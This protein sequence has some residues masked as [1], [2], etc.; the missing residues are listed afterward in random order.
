MLKR[1]RE[2]ILKQWEEREARLKKIRAKEKLMEERG[3]KRR[4]LEDSN[5]RKHDKAVNDEDE[6]L[7]DQDDDTS[8]GDDN[9]SGF[10]K[11]TRDLMGKLGLGTLHAKEEVEEDMS[12]NEVK[13]RRVVAPFGQP[14]PKLTLYRY[15]T[16]RERI[17]S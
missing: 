5:T 1:K 7:L 4:R 3:A 12:K 11:E 15:I 14:L 9:T 13:V 17:P 8:Q 10:S 6:W 16:L 2:E